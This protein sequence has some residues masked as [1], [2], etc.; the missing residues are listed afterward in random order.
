VTTIAD[1]LQVPVWKAVENALADYCEE[2]NALVAEQHRLDTQRPRVEQSASRPHIEAFNREL[3]LY[4]KR[5]SRF[6]QQRVGQTG[7]SVEP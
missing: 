3:R 2:F 7:Q 4:N 5:V 6:L 1:A